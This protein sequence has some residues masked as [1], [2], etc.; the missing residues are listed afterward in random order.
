MKVTEIKAM[1][2]AKN[3]T[4]GKKK[5]ADLIHALQE[6]EGN[7]PCYESGI[8]NCGLTDCLWFDDCQK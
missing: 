6:A 7:V 2:K 8:T 5:K 3:I 1:A 4:I